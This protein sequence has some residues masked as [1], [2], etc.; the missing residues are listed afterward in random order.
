MNNQALIALHIWQIEQNRRRLLNWKEYKFPNIQIAKV[1]F[2]FDKIQPILPI[3][4]IMLLYR[5]LW[6]LVLLIV[7]KLQ[8]RLWTFYFRKQQCVRRCPKIRH[9]FDIIR[10]RHYSSHTKFSQKARSRDYNT[11]IA[12]KC[13]IRR[14]STLR[15]KLD[16]VLF[17]WYRKFWQR[18][19]DSKSVL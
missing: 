16:S 19:N 18:L 3:V 4:E 5:V 2:F 13:L 14:I 12:R 15:E 11:W 7:S 1:W 9:N 17:A 8:F 10:I 6:E